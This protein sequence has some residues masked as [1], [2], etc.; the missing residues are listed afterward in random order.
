M[1]VISDKQ[2]LLM[3]GELRH[4]SIRAVSGT[5]RLQAPEWCCN[6]PDAE[7]EEFSGLLSDM[8]L[9]HGIVKNT[10][11]ER[12]A[13]LKIGY[14]YEIPLSSYRSMILSLK[15]FSEEYRLQRFEESLTEDHD[16]ISLQ[17]MA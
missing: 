3:V 13:I 6:K 11:I 2:I 5:L 12:L 10:N 9:A 8:S 16:L 14:D 4:L 7:I 1:L 15:G 17:L